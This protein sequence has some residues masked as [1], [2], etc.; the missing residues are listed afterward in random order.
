MME[1]IEELSLYIIQL[2]EENKALK[3]EMENL[4]D[5]IKH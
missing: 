1:K 4:K 5:A 3:A 2:N